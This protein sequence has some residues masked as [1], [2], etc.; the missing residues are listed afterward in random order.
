MASRVGTACV[1]GCLIWRFEGS[2]KSLLMLVAAR[3]LRL[4]TRPWGTRRSSSW[5]TGSKT[6]ERVERICADIARHFQDKVAPHGLG[7]QVVTCEREADVL[8][9]RGARSGAGGG[10]V[11]RGNERDSRAEHVSWRRNQDAEERLLDRFR[12]PNDPL[13]I[14]IVTSKLP[15]SVPRRRIARWP[16]PRADRR[17][18][19][20]ARQRGARRLRGRLPLLGPPGKPSL[21]TRACSHTRPTTGEP[22]LRVGAASTGVGRLLWHTLGPKTVELIHRGVHVDAVRDD[23]EALVLDA[24]VLDAVRGTPETDGKSREIEIKVAGRLRRHLDPRFR[25]LGERFETLR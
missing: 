17:A 23:L 16:L 7:A 5:S 13:K 22:D 1:G 14:L 10:D 9:K 20:S 11:R 19:A 21:P 18:E 4:C 12:D 24:D 6:P 3:K 15:G 2:G 25:T 8:Y